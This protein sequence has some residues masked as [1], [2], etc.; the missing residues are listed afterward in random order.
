MAKRR[1]RPIIIWTNGYQRLV[2]TVSSWAPR[3][4][5]ILEQKSTDAMDVDSWSEVRQITKE[6]PKEPVDRYEAAKDRAILL[7]LVEQRVRS[8]RRAARKS[9]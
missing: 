7:E 1:H 9:R 3:L 2:R 5:Y 4:R 8:R 6:L